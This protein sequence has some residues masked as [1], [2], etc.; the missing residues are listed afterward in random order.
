MKLQVFIVASLM[1]APMA[2]AQQGSEVMYGFGGK[3]YKWADERG[4]VHYTRNPPEYGTFSEIDQTK[5]VER[6]FPEETEGAGGSEVYGEEA[7]AKAN[8]G[9]LSAREIIDRNCVIARNNLLLLQ[10]VR[11]KQLTY[12]SSEGKKTTLGDA[13]KAA[14]I[15]SAQNNINHYCK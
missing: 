9:G 3:V 11:G 2:L 6:E 5:P 12:I 7:T 15:Q 14:R 1:L 8:S 4:N 10:N 13:E